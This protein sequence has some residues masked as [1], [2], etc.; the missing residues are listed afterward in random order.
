[1]GKNCPKICS[2]SVIY[3]RL[4]KVNNCPTGE[5]SPNLGPIFRTFFPRNF[6]DKRFFITFSAENSIFP[7]HFWG[8]IFLGIFPEI[9]PRKNVR[10][11]AQKP[12][13]PVSGLQAVLEK[14]AT[15]GSCTGIF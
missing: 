3:E 4:P 7:Q 8:K 9:F 6:L 5:N 15:L 13:T 10:M 2:T 11:Y 1:V 12:E 14:V